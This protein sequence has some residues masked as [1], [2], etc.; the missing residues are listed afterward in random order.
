MYNHAE[1]LKRLW[2]LDPKLNETRESDEAA[3]LK[4]V[5][6]VLGP[7]NEVD[8]A[9]IKSIYADF[10]HE[11]TELTNRGRRMAELIVTYGFGALSLPLLDQEALL[12]AAPHARALKQVESV[13]AARIAAGAVPDEAFFVAAGH[14]APTAKR[15]RAETAAKA[16]IRSAMR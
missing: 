12:L 8:D 15:L 14:D 1:K 5:R 16:A 13:S 2:S 4:T 3:W 9:T 7:S 10:I 11:V 6:A